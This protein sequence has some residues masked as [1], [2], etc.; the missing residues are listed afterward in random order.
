MQNERHEPPEPGE[1]ISLES[2]AVES[3][4]D[5]AKAREAWPESVANN[6]AFLEQVSERRELNESLN[7]VIDRLPR[8]DMSL[9]EAVN[10]GLVSEKQVARLYESLSGLIKLGQGSERAILY[11]PFEFLPDKKWQ[12]KT[13]DL[14]GASEQFGINYVMTLNDMFVAH[15]VRANFVDGDV[16]ETEQRKGDLPRVVKAAHLI[17]KLVE[18]GFMEAG[19]AI[20]MVEQG[21]DPVLQQSAAD[22]LP[23]L[24]DLGLITE[25][26]I[27]QMEQSRN[28]LVRDAV[29]IIKSNKK[30]RTEATEPVTLLSLQ[31]GLRKEF[32]RIDGE[33]HKGL[34]KKRAAWLNQ[35]EKQKAVE[36]TGENV[37]TAIIRNELTDETVAEFLTPEADAASQQALIGGIR[38]AI[39]TKA[40]ANPQ[41]AQE[42]Y[43]KYRGDIIKLFESETPEIKDEIT[44]TFCRLHGLG[45]V[46]DAQLTELNITVPNLAGPFSENL[47]GMEKETREVRDA[48]VAIES[49][50]RLS[51]FIYPA[52]LI[53]GSRLKGYGAPGAD[54]DVGVFIKPETPANMRTELQKLLRETFAN[55]KTNGEVVEFWLEEKGNGL[56]VKDL[57]KQDPS[58]GK[59][60]WTHILFGAAWEGN[61]DTMRELREKL[62]VPYM[63]DTGEEIEGRDARGLFLEELERD[64]L[65]Y[66]LMHKGYER[67]FPAHGGIHTPHSDRIDGDSMF[68]D[69]GY[70]QLAIKLFASRVFLPKLPKQKK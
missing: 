32:K 9:E 20:G 68:W 65:Q 54:V 28:P 44:K 15:D 17:P 21:E 70:R 1:N 60:Y 23:V 49:D 66:R 69:S 10:Q 25:K 46:N 35:K 19:D 29:Q 8:P 7:D 48:L 30:E 36:A 53:F 22:T 50:P 55:G 62:L 61:E 64:T 43:G 34:T 24:A 52:A 51:K 42:L 27:E 33:K 59:N 47:K 41:Q 4:L 58:L 63:H 40:S 38:K 13:E 6:E 57:G 12:P 16:L 14:Q 5:P 11:L 18:K 26:E 45:I 39:E 56:A 3:F 31:K 2:P 67:F 37:A